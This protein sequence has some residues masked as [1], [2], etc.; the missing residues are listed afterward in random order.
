MDAWLRCTEVVMDGE[1]E[2]RCCKPAGHE[3]DRHL[4]ATMVT[5]GD[6]VGLAEEANN[7][8]G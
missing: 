8:R 4:F 7:D 3:G 5:L 1:R 2:R 6:L